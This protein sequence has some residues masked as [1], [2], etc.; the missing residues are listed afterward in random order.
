MFTFSNK[1]NRIY[2]SRGWEIFQLFESNV[3]HFDIFRTGLWIYIQYSLLYE[4]EEQVL[5]APISA[6]T[7][8]FIIFGTSLSRPGD[9]LMGL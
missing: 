3:A 8:L 1:P 7:S 4:G 2:F 9:L 6:T 5:F